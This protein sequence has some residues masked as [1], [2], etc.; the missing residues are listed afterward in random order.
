[1]NWAQLKHR[2]GMDG[3]HAAQQI[4]DGQLGP[5]WRLGDFVI[6]TRQRGPEYALPS[7]ARGLDA[8]RAVGT[9]TPRV[10]IAEP[11]VLVIDYVPPGPPRWAACG[12]HL[13]NQHLKHQAEYGWAS[14]TMLASV[15]FTNELS[16][17]WPAFWIDQ[18]VR[19]LH[20]LVRSRIGSMNV[21]LNQLLTTFTPPVE[22][23][24]LL[25]GDLWSGNVVMGDS[26]PFLIDPSVFWGERLVDVAMMKLFGGFPPQFWRAYEET[27]PIPAD[28]QAAIPYYQLYYVLVH[29]HLYGATYCQHL[30]HILGAYG[31]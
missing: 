13:A 12:Q 20:A 14:P 31:L 26:G 29:I 15:P 19:P 27:Y 11:D 7:E 6:K 8:L 3:H 22:G 16:A 2:L 1:M 9:P 21:R 18:R 10:F 25:H 5:I 28:Y 17:V 24:C 4:A 23:S 30:H